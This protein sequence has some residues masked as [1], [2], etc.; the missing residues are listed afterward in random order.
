[1]LRAACADSAAQSMGHPMAA[2]GLNFRVRLFLAHGNIV[3]LFFFF[4]LQN[5]ARA[6]DVLGL[7]LP[8]ASPGI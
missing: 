2:L 5:A 7:G 4:S 3:C 8:A 6:A 1:M